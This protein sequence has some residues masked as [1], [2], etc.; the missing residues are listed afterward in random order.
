MKKCVQIEKD[1]HS[2]AH[3]WETRVPKLL[4]QNSGHISA[5]LGY[6]KWTTNGTLGN[7]KNSTW[8][9][10]KMPRLQKQQY[11]NM[12]SF[13]SRINRNLALVTTSALTVH[14]STHTHTHTQTRARARTRTHAR[15]H[16]H[17]RALWCQQTSI[18]SHVPYTPSV[19]FSQFTQL[20]TF[21]TIS[22][23]FEVRNLYFVM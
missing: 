8:C 14:F 5:Q 2:Q 9:N 23:Y 10:N 21:S 3:C 22:H 1:K 12:D 15:T 18:S 19:I 13:I 7:I 20:L 4:E 11:K 17:T 6:Y 16:T